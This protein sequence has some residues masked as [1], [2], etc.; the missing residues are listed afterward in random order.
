MSLYKVTMLIQADQ[1]DDPGEWLMDV[2]EEKLDDPTQ[3]RSC[4]IVAM[5]PEIF[6]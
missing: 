1:D 2:V 6:G 4:T 3:L 5:N